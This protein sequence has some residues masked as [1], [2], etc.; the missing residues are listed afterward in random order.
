MLFKIE[1][2]DKEE[3]LAFFGKRH[4]LR[5]ILRQFGSMGLF[6]NFYPI[7]GFVFTHMVAMETFQLSKV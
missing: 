2:N 1:A 4:Y 7:S 3:Q 5:C 6:Q